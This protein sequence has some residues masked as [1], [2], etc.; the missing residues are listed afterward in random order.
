V[1]ETL[2]LRIGDRIPASQPSC[3]QQLDP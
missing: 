2:D 1:K 3:Y